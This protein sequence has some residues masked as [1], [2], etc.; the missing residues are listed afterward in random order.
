MKEL[1]WALAIVSIFIFC[2]YLLFP[3]IKNKLMFWA[4]SS[5]LK[6]MANKKTGKLK[7][8]LLNLSELAK[9]IGKEEEL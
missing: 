9:K 6:K 5:T 1:I 3:L 8:D 4:M 2:R 7:K